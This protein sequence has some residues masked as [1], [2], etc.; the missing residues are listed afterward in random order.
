[1]TKDEQIILE[2]IKKTRMGQSSWD[3]EADYRFAKAVNA[4]DEIEILKAL[5]KSHTAFP[6]QIEIHRKYISKLKNRR[7]R[8]LRRLEKRGV[9]FSGWAGTGYG[10]YALFGTRRTKGWHLKDKGKDASSK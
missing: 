5:L 2:D 3:W 1:M 10:G 6:I 9:L 4:N 8:A 7:L